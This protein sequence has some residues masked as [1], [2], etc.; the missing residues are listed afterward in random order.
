[1]LIEVGVKLLGRFLFLLRGGFISSGSY[2]YPCMSPQRQQQ[3]D[4]YD[5]VEEELE[6]AQSKASL[7]KVFGAG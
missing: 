4:L 7:A 6:A 3:F 5:Q 2:S 1:L